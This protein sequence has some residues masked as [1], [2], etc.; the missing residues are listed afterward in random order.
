VERVEAVVAGAGVVG[1]AVAHALAAAGREVLILEA[2]AAIGTGISARNSGVIHAGLYYPPGGVMA[3]AC[4]AGRRALYDWCDSRGVPHAK[5]GKLVVAV[6]EA[7]VATLDAIRTRAEAN[8]VE[9]LRLLSGPEARALEPALACVAALHS[10]ETGIVDAPALMLSLL[11]AAEAAGAMLALSTPVERVRAEACGFTVEAG[12]AEPMRLGCRLFVNAAGLGAIALAGRIEGLDPAR[13]PPAFFA[14]GVWFA[15]SGRAPFSRLIYPVP[16]PGGLGTHLT[17][18][19]GG[20]AKFGPDVDWVDAPDY[21]V[22]PARGAAF[23]ASVRRWWPGLRA[24]ALTPAYAGVRPKIAP[25]GAPAQDFVV[26]GPAAHGL[27]GLVNLFGIESPGLTSALALA[28]M[29]AEAL[30]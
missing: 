4:V 8:G 3:R 14:K 1:L 5:C 18:D 23:E 11:G 21:A 13:V 25:K 29:V 6:T 15:L 22:D 28:D 9:G 26:Q 2:E 12:G 16:V 10:P 17:L 7:E 30:A 19:L 27:P 20:Q 24:G